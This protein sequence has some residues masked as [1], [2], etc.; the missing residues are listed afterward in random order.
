[1]S[2]HEL[3]T[4]SDRLRSKVTT[5]E[6]ECDEAGRTESDELRSKVTTLERERDEAEHARRRESDELRSKVTTLEWERDA[7]E[8]TRRE[9]SDELRARVTTLERERDDLKR[10]TEPSA[11]GKGSSVLESL[12]KFTDEDDE[13]PRES[14]DCPELPTV[15][16]VHR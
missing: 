5:L 9:E 6:R 7:A 14:H 8:R 2:K 15:A 16:S 1:M 12:E 4:E 10:R 3:R 11:S 13:C